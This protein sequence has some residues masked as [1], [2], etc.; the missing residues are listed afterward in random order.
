MGRPPDPLS[1]LGVAQQKQQQQRQTHPHQGTK[2]ASLVGFL[3]FIGHRNT[4]NRVARGTFESA[5]LELRALPWRFVVHARH[6]D[7]SQR[8][9]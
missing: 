1:S 6:T 4:S 8:G 5:L 7:A 2:R 9:A 3:E